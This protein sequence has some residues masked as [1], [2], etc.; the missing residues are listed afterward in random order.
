LELVSE[1]VAIKN[2]FDL[3]V[4]FS[5]NNDGTGR[6][7]GLARG[8][9]I[10]EGLKKGNMENRVDVHPGWEVEFISVFANFH[11]YRK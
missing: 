9:V 7:D 11:D 6:C 8:G 5:F 4:G 2:F 10:A 1:H 3:I